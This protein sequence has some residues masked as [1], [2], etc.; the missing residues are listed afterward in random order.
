MHCRGPLRLPIV[1]RVIR[2]LGVRA[3]RAVL[4]LALRRR[5]HAAYGLAVLRVLWRVLVVAVRR[6]PA[7]VLV[8]AELGRNVAR[9]RAE[10]RVREAVVGVHVRVMDRL[11]D[12][13]RTEV[14]YGGGMREGK[15]DVHMGL[16]PRAVSFSFI[17]RRFR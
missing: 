4:R 13:V 10:R 3:P 16:A 12:C 2:G 6:V 1:V 5:C 8:R 14:R 9:V 11:L 15:G 17:R 7:V